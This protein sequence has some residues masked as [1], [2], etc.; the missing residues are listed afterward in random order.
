MTPELPCFDNL[1]YCS[2]KLYLIR[3]TGILDGI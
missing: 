3:K 2:E 1:N